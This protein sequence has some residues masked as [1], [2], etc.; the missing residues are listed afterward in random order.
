MGK[1]TTIVQKRVELLYFGLDGIGCCMDNHDGM[2]ECTHHTWD[3][4]FGWFLLYD[5][6]YHN[7]LQKQIKNPVNSWC[8][9]HSH[10]CLCRS[11]SVDKLILVFKAFDSIWGKHIEINSATWTDSYMAWGSVVKIDCSRSWDMFL[12]V[13]IPPVSLFLNESE[14]QTYIDQSENCILTSQTTE[15]QA[16]PGL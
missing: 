9:H 6:G 13:W 1:Q 12:D 15:W 7:H 2:R 11:T 3:A 5:S 14:L 10:E 8:W 4:A 16:W